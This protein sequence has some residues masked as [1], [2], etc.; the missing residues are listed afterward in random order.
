MHTEKFTAYSL[1]Q[2]ICFTKEIRR[3]Y[4]I[5]TFNVVTL[6]TFTHNRRFPEV[7][8]SEKEG[9]ISDTDLHTDCEY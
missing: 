1:K 6:F 8:K 9:P 5:P 4:H 3:Y 2:G 7:A